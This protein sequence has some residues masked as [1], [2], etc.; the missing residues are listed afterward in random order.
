[1]ANDIAEKEI[2]IVQT[3][4]DSNMYDDQTLVALNCK[5]E[6]FK[7]YVDFKVAGLDHEQAEKL[8]YRIYFNC[9]LFN[10]QNP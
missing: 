8:S 7:A 5:V 10:S 2:E 9:L 4:V 3:R 6:K 1:M